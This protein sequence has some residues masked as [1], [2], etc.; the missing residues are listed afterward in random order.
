MSG[1]PDLPSSQ[2][3]PEQKPELS[4]SLQLRQTGLSGS[5]GRGV[6]HFQEHRQ[7][8]RQ[9]QVSV[10]SAV[11]SF[12]LVNF[13]GPVRFHDPI[14]KSSDHS[15]LYP[16]DEDLTSKL[17]SIQLSC[18]PFVSSQ[19]KNMNEDVQIGLSRLEISNMKS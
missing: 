1:P 10:R 7:D 19:E 11:C 16:L 8:R 17:S 6:D 15:V 14:Y 13:R 2:P 12:Q 5:P 18:E 3:P 9:D 4:V